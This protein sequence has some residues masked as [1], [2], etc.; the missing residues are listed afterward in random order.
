MSAMYLKLLTLLR[1]REKVWGK[2]DWRYISLMIE[3][4]M[5]S[6]TL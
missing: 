5:N 3:A 1:K 4:A 2:L 6:F